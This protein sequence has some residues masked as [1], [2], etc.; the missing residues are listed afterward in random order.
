MNDAWHR[1]A[2]VVTGGARGQG[3]ALVEQ[4]LRGGATVHVVDLLPPADPA[5]QPLRAM[6]TGRLVEWRQDVAD[7]QGWEQLATAIREDG[8]PLQA[9]VNN[10]GITGNRHTVTQ[11][12]LADWDRVVATNLTGSMLGIRALAPLMERGAAIVNVSSTTGM[13]GYPSAAY[14]ATKWALRGLTRSAAMELAPRGIRVNCVCPGVVD[15]EMIRTSPALVAA[16]QGVIPLQ[17]MA[18]P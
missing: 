18:Q 15:T 2:A 8:L 1:K 16:L 11:V 6:A 17:Q 10:A 5:W 12:E 4:L 14:S 3:A 13:T 9:L 7:A